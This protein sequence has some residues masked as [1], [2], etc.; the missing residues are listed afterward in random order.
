MKEGDVVVVVGKIDERIR[1]ADMNRP[2]AGTIV[3]KFGKTIWVLLDSGDL[4][5]GP[6]HEVARYEEQF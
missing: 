1:K 5:I 3:L 4:W 2:A 6:D